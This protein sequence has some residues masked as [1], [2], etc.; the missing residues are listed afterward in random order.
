MA[1]TTPS[2]TARKHRRPA[3]EREPAATR[4]LLWFPRL[5]ASHAATADPPDQG[6]NRQPGHDRCERGDEPGD[7]V[8]GCLIDGSDRLVDGAEG[9]PTKQAGCPQINDLD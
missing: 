8:D 2:M 9:R 3:Q 5:P 4:R 1:G 7:G 6:D